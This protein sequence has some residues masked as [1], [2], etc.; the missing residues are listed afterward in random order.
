M[1]VPEVINNVTKLFNVAYDKCTNDVQ[2]YDVEKTRA[3]ALG[4]IIRYGQDGFVTKGIEVPFSLPLIDP[5][6][7]TALEETYCG[8]LDS[9]LEKDNRLYIGDYKT[10]SSRTFGNGYGYWQHMRTH[11]QL[12]HYNLACRQLGLTIAGFLWDVIVKPAIEPKQVTKKEKLEL[13]NGSY[14]GMRFEGYNGEAKETPK[15]YGVRCFG[16]INNEPDKYYYRRVLS[17]PPSVMLDYL[18]SM[19]QMAKEMRKIKAGAKHAIHNYDACHNYNRTCEYHQICNGND[20]AK[21]EYEQMPVVE[22]GDRK[23]P[24]G[25]LS[26]SRFGCFNSC[27]VKWQYRYVEKI[28]PRK[29]E[30]QNSLAIGSMYHEAMEIFRKDRIYGEQITLIT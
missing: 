11:P 10:I 7:N 15:M 19:V 21:G 4:Y 6:T 18:N 9:I 28:Q 16:H 26:P 17:C 14:Y 25:S 22:D 23:T 13:E 29:L 27:Q 5:A 1:P 24:S 20:P 3:M 8:I 30:Y 2:K 12:A